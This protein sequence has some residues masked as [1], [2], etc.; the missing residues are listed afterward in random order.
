MFFEECYPLGVKLGFQNNFKR[1]VYGFLKMF[2][3]TTL[4]DL[5]E[6]GIH[7]LKSVPKV[8]KQQVAAENENVKNTLKILFFSVFE[9]SQATIEKLK[10]DEFV[11]KEEL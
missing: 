2:S 8:L 11:L 1:Y 4:L 9:F 5:R 3:A 6:K 10:S 7:P